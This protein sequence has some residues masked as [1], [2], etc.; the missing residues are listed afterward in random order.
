MQ[1]IEPNIPGNLRASPIW[2]RWLM[3]LLFGL[4][5]Y[6]SPN[7][8]FT[9]FTKASKHSIVVQ[10]TSLTYSSTLLAGDSYASMWIS[11]VHFY[12]GERS[13]LPVASDLIWKYKSWLLRASIIRKNNGFC[14][15]IEKAS[16][17][18]QNFQRSSPSTSNYV[19][20]HNHNLY[21][22]FFVSVYCYSLLVVVLQ[23]FIISFQILSNSEFGTF[24]RVSGARI[25]EI[26]IHQQN[27]HI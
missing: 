6:S 12:N 7:I 14:I 3:S 23:C 22:A 27:V 11:A 16:L 9:P 19:H 1:S 8:S 2:S 20:L 21:G 17:C 24:L 5:K 13:L 18:I 15:R 10:L 25:K 4:L 26:W